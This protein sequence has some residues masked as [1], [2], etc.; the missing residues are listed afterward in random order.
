MIS[1][2]M[3]AG[4]L[5]GGLQSRAEIRVLYCY[6]LD[7]LNVPVPLE[8]VKEKLHFEGIVNFFESAYAVSELVDNGAVTVEKEENYEIYT[9]TDI[10]RNVS[11]ELYRSVPLTIR[12]RGV[13]IAREA[14]SRR[15]N[16]H[17]NKVFIERDE[18]GVTVT[19]KIMDNDLELAS[20]KLLVP[21]MITANTVKENFLS[22]PLTVIMKITETLTGTKL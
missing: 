22:D 15:N 2:A 1:D 5:P 7:E 17:D 10:G 4:V 13:E 11:N 8:R 20:V 16:E 18:K 6:I 14:V 19:C 12:E 3:N 9:I 21:D